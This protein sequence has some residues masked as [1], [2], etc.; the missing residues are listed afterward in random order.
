MIQADSRFTYWLTTATNKH[1]EYV[2]LIT[3]PRQKW[4]RESAS[5]SRYNQTACI[6]NLG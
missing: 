3:F 6:V 5:K 2:I 4:F 1:S